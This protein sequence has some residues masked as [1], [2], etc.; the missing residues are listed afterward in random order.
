MLY[1]RL[2]V[3]SCLRPCRLL[4][5]TLLLIVLQF[6]PSVAASAGEVSFAAT[7]AAADGEFQAPALN[8]EGWEVKKFEQVQRCLACRYVQ[9]TAGSDGSSSSQ[10]FARIMLQTCPSLPSIAASTLR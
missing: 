2:Q 5:L 1:P 10:S 9:E 4:A 8:P 3:L 7:S 6:C